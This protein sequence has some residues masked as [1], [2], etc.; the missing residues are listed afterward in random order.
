M[1]MPVRNRSEQWAAPLRALGFSR[2]RATRRLRRGGVV[3]ESEGAWLSLRERAPREAP[4][5]LASPL[6]AP[7]LWK[8]VAEN[9]HGRRVFEFPARVLDDAALDALSDADGEPGAPFEAAI[10]WALASRRGEVAE[11][12]EAPSDEEARSWVGADAWTVVC[13]SVARQGELVREPRRLSARFPLLHAVPGDL[14][15]ARRAWLSKLLVEAERRWRMCRVGVTGAP[16]AVS[17]QAEVD[18]SGA[19]RVLLEGLLGAAL[20]ALQ[21]LV[22]WTVAPA[23]VIVDTARNYRVFDSGPD[24]AGFGPAGRSLTRADCAGAPRT[25]PQPPERG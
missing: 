11:G 3:F 10:A 17:V 21:C 14:P 15:P 4:D 6:G 12:W 24:L 22:A 19:P 8:V 20:A 1:G 23:E 13:G 2:D 18:L 25:A 16:G 5:P 9:G 7:G